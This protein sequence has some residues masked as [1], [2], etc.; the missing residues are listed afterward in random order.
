MHSTTDSHASKLTY[1]QRFLSIECKFILLCVQSLSLNVIQ[2]TLNRSRLL[3]VLSR[4]QLLSF[5]VHC[6]WNSG[7]RDKDWIQGLEI[8]LAKN[9]IFHWIK[10]CDKFISASLVFTLSNL[11]IIILL[12]VR[13]PTTTLTGLHLALWARS[14]YMSSCLRH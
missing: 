6:K 5:Q 8:F 9:L 2:F 1:F 13:V 7:E 4:I 11:K 3:C 10:C 14:T 12:L